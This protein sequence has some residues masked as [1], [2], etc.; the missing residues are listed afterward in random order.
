MDKRQKLLEV[1]VNLHFGY[2]TLLRMQGAKR[3][4][5][6]MPNMYQIQIALNAGIKCTIPDI[7]EAFPLDRDWLDQADFRG[8]LQT[9]LGE[10]T[11]ERILEIATNTVSEFD[12][13]SGYD[14]YAFDPDFFANYTRQ[15]PENQRFAMLWRDEGSLAFVKSK[16]P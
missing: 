15:T 6:A 4:M 7:L 12:F 16:V 2:A 10:K 11:H 1:A 8:H 14:C 9:I 5:A 13:A 3:C